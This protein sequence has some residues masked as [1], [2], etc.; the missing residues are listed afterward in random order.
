MAS[1]EDKSKDVLK[2]MKALRDAGWLVYLRV[3]PDMHGFIIPG[4]RSE[5]DAPCED[6]EVGKGKWLCEAMWMGEGFIPGPF[7]LGDTA[8]EVV[9][10]VEIDCANQ[11]ALHKAIIN[12]KTPRKASSL[13]D[14]QAPRSPAREST[15]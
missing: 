6:I 2:T 1:E 7:R 4:S 13:G 8:E 15:D 11:M 5:Y 12:K 14:E 9:G 3:A 10:F